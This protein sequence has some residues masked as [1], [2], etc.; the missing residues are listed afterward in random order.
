[1]AGI[2]PRIPPSTIARTLMLGTIQ[3][4]FGRYCHFP[5]IR[6]KFSYWPPAPA[7]HYRSKRSE[8]YSQTLFMP[9]G[10]CCPPGI[11]NENSLRVKRNLPID[12]IRHIAALTEE[13]HHFFAGS[14][15]FRP[16]G[17]CF[18]ILLKPSDF[19][20]LEHEVQLTKFPLL[21]LSNGVTLAAQ[22]DDL[23]ILDADLAPDLDERI[24]KRI[25]HGHQ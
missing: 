9:M 18:R 12:H 24:F 16:S 22:V 13:L 7:L 4:P 1:M 20:S 14:R 3:C 17:F 23:D 10:L 25:T 2:I 5:I 11:D 15:H 6:E 8:L 19:I 21:R